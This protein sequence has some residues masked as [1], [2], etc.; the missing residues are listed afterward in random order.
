MYILI[1]PTSKPS[2]YEVWLYKREVYGYIRGRWAAHCCTLVVEDDRMMNEK[3][4]P[5]YI[6]MSPLLIDII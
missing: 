6:F 2:E 1:G 5:P 3:K 4:V